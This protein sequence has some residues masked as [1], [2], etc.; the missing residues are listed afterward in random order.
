YLD[1]MNMELRKKRYLK[2][3]ADKY[4]VQ[5]QTVEEFRRII[6]RDEQFIRESYA[7][8]TGWIKSQD[9]VEMILHDSV[10]ILG[11]FI[12]T[13]T[14]KCNRKEDILFEEPCLI[15]TILEDLILLEN[16]EELFEPFLFQLKTEETFRDII[17]RV[18][19]FEGK[20][21]KD[22]KLRHFTDLQT[23]QRK[24]VDFVNVGEEND[25]SLV[26]DFQGGILKMPC[27]T[28][29]DNTEKVIRNL[30]ALEQ[31]HYPFSAYVCNYIAFLDFL[32]D[33]EQDVDL[34]VKKGSIAEMVNKLCLGIVDYG[35]YYYEI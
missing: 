12:Q 30:M 14:Q 8:S 33:T 15:T 11:F 4:G 31:C 17:L 13:G 9:F 23:R 18:F 28:A 24:S 7:E 22:V 35:Y 19:G 25:L 2:G 27:F 29:E 16:Q 34:L 6:E 1:Y 10:F 5:L 3:I 21:Q 32:I 20:L 26:I